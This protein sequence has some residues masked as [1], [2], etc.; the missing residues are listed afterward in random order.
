MYKVSILT[1]VK[2]NYRQI[3]LTIQSVINQS[4][5]DKEYIIVD[6]YSTDGT[7]EI[8][9]KYTKKY[10]FIKSYR[11]KD[12]NLYEALNFGIKN[13]SGEYLHLL[14]SGDIY[15]SKNSL[16]NIYNFSA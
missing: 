7:Y 16:Q 5:K 9:E 1:V 13:L 11:K 12:N 3:D 10:S 8:I 2:N 15:Y 6:G 14:H 4:I